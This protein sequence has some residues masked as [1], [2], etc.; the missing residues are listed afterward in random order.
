MLVQFKAD[1]KG[2]PMPL[3]SGLVHEATADFFE[4]DLLGNSISAG[5]K[6][7]LI[8]MLNPV[9]DDLELSMRLAAAKQFI[10]FIQAN[11]MDRKC[12]LLYSSLL[13]WHSLLGRCSTQQ[14]C[15]HMQA[16]IGHAD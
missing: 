9:A 15:A 3:V 14:Q 13:Q 2:C 8:A 11:R 12:V 16:D 10:T 5:T 7:P 1:G 4:E 6:L